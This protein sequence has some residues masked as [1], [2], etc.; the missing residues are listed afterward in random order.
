MFEEQGANREHGTELR[1]HQTALSAKRVVDVGSDQQLLF[2]FSGDDLIY[3]GRGAKS[4]LTASDGWLVQKFTWSAGK[5]TSRK[6]GIG[7]WDDR[8]TITYA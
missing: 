5:P 2:E 8:V 1:E 7:A 3:L 4:L 6:S